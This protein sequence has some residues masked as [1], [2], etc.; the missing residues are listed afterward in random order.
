MGK[1]DEQKTAAVKNEI[2]A[3]SDMYNRSP[4][5][6]SLVSALHACLPSHVACGPVSACNIACAGAAHLV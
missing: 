3:F 6:T 1:A 4:P 5:H 2:A